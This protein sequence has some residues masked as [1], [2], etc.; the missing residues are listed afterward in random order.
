M[1]IIMLIFP[2]LN[3]R[4]HPRVKCS[5]RLRLSSFY[6]PPLLSQVS[7]SP[8]DPCARPG[9]PPPPSRSG[10]AEVGQEVF[11]GPSLGS[12]A[13]PHGRSCSHMYA[14]KQQIEAFMHCQDDIGLFGNSSLCRDRRSMAPSM[15][16]KR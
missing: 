11:P 5:D 16:S 1:I 4:D 2:I 6:S 8:A 7:S 9:A 3:S 14:L 15:T 13:M 12:H 10:D